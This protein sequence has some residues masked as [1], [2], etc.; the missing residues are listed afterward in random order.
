MPLWKDVK[1]V[2]ILRVSVLPLPQTGLT[3]P[4]SVM[5]R[6]GKQPQLWVTKLDPYYQDGEARL[7]G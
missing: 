6:I 1:G 3:Q 5:A 7:P 2:C 4:S